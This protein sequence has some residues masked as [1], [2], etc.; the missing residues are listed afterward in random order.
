MLRQTSGEHQIS[1]LLSLRG[2]SRIL[3]EEHATDSYQNLLFSVIAFR[4]AWGCYPKNVRVVTHAFKA[5][6]FMV[7]ANSKSSAAVP[8]SAADDRGLPR[9]PG[10]E[11][12]KLFGA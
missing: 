11:Y 4:K 12:G 5:K 9:G 6:R 8:F 7:R 10:T 1:L 3:L 2:K